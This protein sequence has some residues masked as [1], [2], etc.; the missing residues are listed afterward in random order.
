MLSRSHRF[1][2]YGSLDYTYRH[3]QSVRGPI[4]SVRYT[5]NPKRKS[6]RVAVVV[7]KKVHKSAVTRNRIR[8]RVYEIVR[9]HEDTIPGAYDIVITIFQDKAATMPASELTSI[10]TKQLTA[11]RTH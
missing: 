5:A 11:L 9:N 2:G 8:R 7:S 10:I 3:G 1:H 6:Y 4:S